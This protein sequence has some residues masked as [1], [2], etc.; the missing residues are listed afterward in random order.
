MP[1][2]SVLLACAAALG[3]ALAVPAFAETV[4]LEA[5]DGVKIYGDFQRAE[6]RSRATCCFTWQVPIGANTRL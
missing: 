1:L 4:T 6:G 2:R 3:P 5:K